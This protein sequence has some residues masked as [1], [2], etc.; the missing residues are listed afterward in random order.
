[1]KRKSI[2]VQGG[3]TADLNDR[4]D[5]LAKRELEIVQDIKKAVG[6]R[7]PRVLDFFPEFQH[8]LKPPFANSLDPTLDIPTLLPFYQTLIVGISPF[9]DEYTFERNYGLPIPM[10]IELAEKGRLVFVLNGYPEDYKNLSYLSALVHEFTPPSVIRFR[11][12]WDSLAARGRF[13][14]FKEL[15]GSLFKGRISKVPK[16][17][18]YLKHTQSS[19]DKVERGAIAGF[20][21]LQITGARGAIEHIKDIAKDHPEE[22]AGLINTVYRPFFSDHIYGSLSG[23]H[24]MVR[25]SEYTK[26]CSE[27]PS[28]DVFFISEEMGRA[29]VQGLQVCAPKGIEVFKDVD[30]EYSEFRKAL[31]ALDSAVNSLKITEALE[32][33]EAIRKIWQKVDD[34]TKKEKRFQKLVQTVGVVGAF[35]AKEVVAPW[36]M[37]ELFPVLLGICS[38]YVSEPLG[39]AVARLTTESNIRVIFDL[40]K[41]IERPRQHGSG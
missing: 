29:L 10:M 35:A 6:Q 22:A 39:K 24:A 26:Y 8:K 19:I 20:I 11:S 40:K 41:S 3:P 18:S 16:S 32:Q 23:Q 31:C 5:R 25:S 30:V 34:I 38:I 12:G 21:E 9:R 27:L 4:L 14:E 17:T 7:P 1:M 13:D 15:G 37:K 28:S 33:S 36:L 2:S